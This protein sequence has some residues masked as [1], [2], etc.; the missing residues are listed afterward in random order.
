MRVPVLV[1][2][3]LHINSLC[4][5]AVLLPLMDSVVCCASHFLYDTSK[6]RNNFNFSVNLP[7]VH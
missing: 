2:F 3:Q 6:N 1:E 7:F 5:Y 4:S